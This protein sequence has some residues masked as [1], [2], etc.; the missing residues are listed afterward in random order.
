MLMSV[1]A[2][3]IAALA[4]V[5]LGQLTACALVAPASHDGSASFTFELRFSEEFS[6]SYKTLRDHTFTV[7]GGEVIRA[8][9][10]ERPGNIRWEITVRPPSDAA[11]TNPVRS[12]MACE[13]F[14][15][16]GVKYFPRMPFTVSSENSGSRAAATMRQPETSL[17]LG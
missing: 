3:V 12:T 5:S 11:V 2:R 7:T 8:R 9:R 17:P 13:Y 16:S 14:C 6:I 1:S 4:F 10:L 15:I